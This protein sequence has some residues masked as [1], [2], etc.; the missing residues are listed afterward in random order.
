MSVEKLSSNAPDKTIIG[1]RPGDLRFNNIGGESNNESDTK[2]ESRPSRTPNNV[3]S[4]RRLR[5]MI[6][7]LGAA[8]PI[9]L[10][11]LSWFPY[12]KTSVQPSISHYY[13]THLR[14]IF[15]GVLCGVGLFL[16]CYKGRSNPVIWK[17]DN[18][19]TNLAGVMAFGVA[20]VPTTL[21]TKVKDCSEKI[22]SIIPACEEWL[23]WLHYTCAGLLF[24][25]FS[26]LAINVFTLGQ[27][28]DEGTPNSW[29]NENNIY[30]FCGYSILVFIAMVP[31]AYRLN[32]FTYSTLVFEALSLFAFG[33]AWLI[34]GRIMGDKGKVGEKIYMERNS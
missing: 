13:Y 27:R 29:M 34:K 20:F 16:I 15:T 19:L 7:L 5:R 18:F 9:V 8:L 22:Y 2:H 12:F 17:N 21:E 1:D 11:L 26:I 31:I 33:T 14:E 28:K 30:R 32:L 6:G 23:G 3:F 10:V 24:V 25:S 4:Y